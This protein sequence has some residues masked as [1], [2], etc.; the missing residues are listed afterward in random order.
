MLYFN[1][2]RKLGCAIVA[3]AS[4][5]ALA[6]PTM[7]NQE[8]KQS[9]LTEEEIIVI[10]QKKRLA[11]FRE[12]ITNQFNVSGGS[13]QTGQYPRFAGPVCPS[14]GGLSERQ[15]SA[16]EDRIRQIARM[17]D[18]P[19]AAE[20][21]RPNL[22]VAVIKD[23]KAE[24]ELLRKKKN[25]LFGSLSHSKRDAM[26]QSGGPVYSWKSVETMGSD[27]R[28]NAAG[29]T[30]TFMAGSN[31]P[32]LGPALGGAQTN[33]QT[34]HVKSKIARS[35]I[36]GIGYSYLLIESDALKGISAAQLAD[37]AA[38]VSLIDIDVSGKAKAP[39]GSILALFSETEDKMQLP[40]SLSEGDLLLLKGLYKVPANVD[41]PLQRSAMLHT[42]NEA[43]S[44]GDK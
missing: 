28:Y 32:G 3:S 13:R 9:A 37:Y 15:A 27:S 6:S 12:L 2:F 10:G 40:Q 31:G 4:I 11:E 34:T 38:M 16:I 43:A 36:E 23:G 26:E 21:C 8:S 1:S 29:G 25:R 18:I 44:P 19:A 17:A 20:D 35:T 41:A 5:F 7:A 39:A 22:F 30:F 14:V 33:G 24:I 42:M